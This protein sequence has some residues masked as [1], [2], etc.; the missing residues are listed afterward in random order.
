[1]DII[2]RTCSKEKGRE[3]YKAPC[4]FQP[5]DVRNAKVRPDGK[6]SAICRQCKKKEHRKYEPGRLS[7]SGSPF[8]DSMA[9]IFAKEGM[10]R[11][12]RVD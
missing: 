3:V 7:R 2:C 1:M 8:R 11:D 5:R 4:L 9:A 10:A 6:Q 12:R